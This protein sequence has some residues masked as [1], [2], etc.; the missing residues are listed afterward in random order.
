[1]P[2]IDKTRVI[3]KHDTSANWLKATNFIPYSG[4]LIL[5]TD[6]NK[7]KMGDGV[8]KV[9][10]LPFTTIDAEEYNETDMEK[11]WN[12][13]LVSGDEDTGVY[14]LTNEEV[15]NIWNNA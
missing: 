13:T 5:Y 3:S 15:T 9:S 8:T 10:D 11:L 14:E 7:I 1:M 6:V 12:E 4:E 2:K